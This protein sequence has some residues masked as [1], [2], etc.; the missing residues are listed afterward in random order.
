LAA[1]DLFAWWS[2][3]LLMRLVCIGGGPAGLY[4]ALLL[5]KAFPQLECEVFE[6]NKPDDTFGWGV[7]FSKETLGT[8]ADADPESYREIELRF[9]YWDDIEVR[10]NGK[11]TTSTG[12]GFCGLARRDLLAILQQ[13]CEQLGVRLHFQQE[14]PTTPV[15]AAD[16]VIACD[17]VHSPIREKYAADFKPSLDWRKC[18]FTWLG[19]TLPL[20]AFTFF[21]KNTA[22]GLFQVHAYPFTKTPMQPSGATSTFIVE[23]REEVWRAA[24]LETAS[25]PETVAFLNKS[26]WRTFPTIRCESWVRGNMVLMGDAVHTAH[27]SIGSGTKL[28]MEDAIALR[29]AFVKEGWNVEAALARYQTA[30]LPETI[31]VQRA[32]QTSLEWFENAARYAGLEPLQLT[33]S[34]MTRSKRITWA[35]LRQRDPMLVAAVDEWFATSQGSRRNSDGSA[36]PPLFAPMTLRSLTLDNRV[37]VSPMCQYSATDGVPDDWHLVHLGSRAIGGAGLV[38]TEMTNVSAEGRITH[39]CTGIWSDAQQAAWKRVV[40]FVHRHSH[41]KIGLQLAHAGR[42]G[43]CQRPW[44]GDGPLGPQEQPWQTMGP[45]ALPFAR[46]WHA[47]KEMTTADLATVKAQ[48]VHG[49]KR[50]DA[51]GFDLLELHMAHGYLLSSFLS[52]LS[53]RRTDA[54]GGSLDKRMAFPLEVFDAVRAVWPAHK[55]I[56][57]RVSASDW[58]GSEGMTIEDTVVLAVALKARG[59]DV[60]DVSSGGNVPESKPEYGRMYQVPFAE[61]VKLGAQLPVMAVGGIQGADHANTVIAA[62]RADLCALARPHLSDPSLVN[63]HAQDEGVDSIA[64]PKQ[65]ALVKPSRRRTE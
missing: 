20:R 63:R 14:L 55:P 24:G 3:S 31:R 58:L 52:P 2:N 26:I 10:A 65:Y 19:T 54:Y 29:D 1:L 32:A 8:L 50:A 35:N 46:G 37:V 43:S 6:K 34:L 9:A 42:K 21:F 17:G 60:I 61:A 13:R 36:P 11:V 16:L 51:A 48:F 25:E 5:K 44:E 62:G 39:G 56:S 33:F 57:V 7:V 4:S 15:P 47:P 23:C 64:W 49:A 22:H 45:S 12:H 40:D 59:C 53:N 27:Y 30:R 28:A 41:A 18:K 38:I